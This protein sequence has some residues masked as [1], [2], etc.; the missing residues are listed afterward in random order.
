MP[1]D[2]QI[3]LF[4]NFDKA[5]REQGEIIVLIYTSYFME[6][7]AAQGDPQKFA[8]YT[9]PDAEGLSNP[10]SESYDVKKLQLLGGK[11]FQLTH[12]QT[13]NNGLY[14]WARFERRKSAKN[15]D[16]EPFIDFKKVRKNEFE[17]Y[18]DAGI[19]LFSAIHSTSTVLEGSRIT[20]RQEPGRYA[21]KS[22]VFSKHW[23]R[24]LLAIRGLRR[25]IH[26]P[27]TEKSINGAFVESE[28]TSGGFSVQLADAAT[29]ENLVSIPVHA[30]GEAMTFASFQPIEVPRGTRLY[31]SVFRPFADTTEIHTGKFGRIQFGHYRCALDRVLAA[32]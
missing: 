18:I 20:S 22:C 26:N 21:A 8:K 1:F 28:I 19:E 12:H 10:W 11:K 17:P 7:A 15:P 27:S 5:L 23:T 13:S 32:L 2:E 29:G 14:A 25:L 3:D 31:I 4:A 24:N 16:T 9:D 30:K 6:V